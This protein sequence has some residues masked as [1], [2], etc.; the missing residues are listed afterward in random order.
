MRYHTTEVLWAAVEEAFTHVTPDYLPE[1]GTEF[2]YAMT[3][4]V[5]MPMF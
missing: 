3:M 4:K 2:N 1:H 5:S